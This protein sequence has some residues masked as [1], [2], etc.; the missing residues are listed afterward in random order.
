[1]I[2]LAVIMCI[3]GIIGA[4]LFIN[5]LYQDWDCGCLTLFLLGGGYIGAIVGVGTKYGAPGVAI[6]NIV[7]IILGI[8][9]LKAGKSDTSSGS[10]YSSSINYMESRKNDPHTCGNCTKYSATKGECRLNGSQKSAEDSCS[11]W[12]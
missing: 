12:C 11:S 9:A 6:V 5:F 2:V 3:L 7:G 8:I 4:Y 10:S 1:M